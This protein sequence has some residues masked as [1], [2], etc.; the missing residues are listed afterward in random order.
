MKIV[1]TLLILLVFAGCTR[2]PSELT[3]ATFNLWYGGLNEGRQVVDTVAVLKALDADVFA[4]QEVRGESDPCTAEHCPPSGPSIAPELADALGYYL[5]EETRVSD[6]LWANAII[7]RYPIVS[8]LDE[9]FGVVIDVDGR[10]IA[11]FNVHLADFPYQPYQLTNIEYGDAPMLDDAASAV[12]A[13]QAA[14]GPAI[15]RV[16]DVAGQLTDIDLVVI[17]GDFNEPSHLDWTEKAA[18][19]GRHPMKVAFP[20]SATL[21]NRGFIDGY[22]SFRPDEVAYPGFT[23]TPL[24]AVDD[25]NE[26]HDRIDFVYLKGDNV[27]VT[28]AAVAGESPATSDIV[29]TPWPSDHRAVVVGLRF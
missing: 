23:Y 16:L 9:D 2:Q 7:S 5:F 22:R 18:N 19:A 21:A 10:H 3:V 25:E 4:L 29:A 27:R 8:I 1:T 28:S 24:A 15:A 14:R 26:H 17:C 12:A 20:T 6:A 13:A 11:V